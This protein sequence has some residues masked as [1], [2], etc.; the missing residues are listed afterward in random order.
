MVEIY[1]LKVFIKLFTAN[2]Y[3][4]YFFSD[5]CHDVELLKYDT[6]E[7]MELIIIVKCDLYTVSI[8]GL[9]A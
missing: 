9:D 5:L 4:V 7:L 1:F 6:M 3:A 2:H 8:I